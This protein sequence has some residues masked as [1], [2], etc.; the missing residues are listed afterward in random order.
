MAKGSN[1]AARGRAKHI[2]VPA[3]FLTAFS[4]AVSALLLTPSCAEPCQDNPKD[5]TIVQFTQEECKCCYDLDEFI[6]DNDYVYV[7]FYSIKGRLNIDINSKFEQ[8]ANEWKFS[9]VSF[10]RID[11]DKD[12]DM[13]KKWVEPHMVPTN[14]MYKFG[15]PVEVRPKDFEQIR[16]RYQGSP[17]GQKWMLTKYLGEEDG[18]NLHYSVPQLSLKKHSK[19]IK[20]HEIA[21][22]GYFKRENDLQHRIFSEAIWKLHQ[23]I[24]RDDLGA[25]F[26][27]VTLQSIAKKKSAEV[28]SLVA[29]V[30]GKAVEQDGVFNSN[31]WTT[32]A[33]SDFV[34][35]FLP[36]ADQ[37]VQHEKLSGDDAEQHTEL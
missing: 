30:Q 17:E 12:R 32:K 21:I 13:A 33:V 28:P 34:R 26:G 1:G 5:Y 10:G 14:V 7:L 29:F 18:S 6:Q 19:F 25:A 35:P 22:I 15:R 20:K 36:L 11:T 9:R 37:E 8:L 27:T 23:E 31:K 24:D 3:H 2:H 16:D 4:V